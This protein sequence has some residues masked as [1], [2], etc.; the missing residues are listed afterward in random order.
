MMIQRFDANESLVKKFPTNPCLGSRPYNNV[1]KT[2][3]SYEWMDYQTVQ[4]R[5]AEFGAG[6]VE[7]HK[8]AGAM[9]QNYGIGLWCQNRP[10]WQITGRWRKD[11]D[12]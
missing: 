1:T 5:R 9:E 11:M 7:L 2:F 10:E 3:G 4:R 12:D 8:R 6:L